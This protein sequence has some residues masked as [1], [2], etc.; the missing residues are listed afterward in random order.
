[1]GGL[2][3][4][5]VIFEFLPMG[6]FVKVTAMDVETRVEVSTITPANLN[7]SQ[8]EQAALN[9]LKYVLNKRDK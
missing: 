9:K 6:N 2:M 5:E 4:Q 1:M 7:Q 3:T 8:Q